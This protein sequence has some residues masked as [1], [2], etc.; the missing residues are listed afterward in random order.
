MYQL[1][2]GEIARMNS[3]EGNMAITTPVTLQVVS[4]IQPFGN[5]AAGGPTRYRCMVSDSELT[6]IAVLP[7]HLASLIEEAKISRYTVI[8]ITK[9]NVSKKARPGEAP[10]AFIIILEAE[11]LG[12]LEEKIG[13]P[14]KA[15]TGATS[16]PAQQ[17]QQQQQPVQPPQQ[18]NQPSFAQHQPSQQQQAYANTFMN[19]VEDTKPS[20]SA[21]A[22]APVHRGA[23]PPVHPIRDLNPYHNKWTIRARVTQK[24]PIKTWNKPSSQGRLFSVNLL[25]E[26]GEIRATTF[27]QQVDALYPLFEVGKVYYISNAQVKMARQQFSNVNNQYELTFDGNTSIEQCV[28]AVDM[29]QEHFDFIPLASLAKFEKGN[30]VDVLCVVQQADGVSEIT[31]K[32]TERKMVKRDLVLVDRSGFQVRATLWGQEAQAFDGHNEPVV[33]FKGIRVGDFGGRSLSLPS[34]G[35]I[36]VNPDI[37]EAHALRGW[38]D[39]EGRGAQFQ[40][41]GGEAGGGAPSQARFEAQLKTMAQVRDENLGLSDPVYFNLKGT[42]VFVRNTALAYP[43]CPSAECNKKVIED[44]S[45]RW[46]CE[47]CARSYDTPDYRYIFSVSVSDETG[48]NWLQCFD[49]VGRQLFGCT[50]R[51]MVELQAADEPAYQ[52]RLNEATFKEFQFRCRAKS[53]MFNET[54]RVRI[55]IVSM[56]PVDYAAESKRLARLIESYA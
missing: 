20:F 10:M 55:S 43:S 1:S 31:A 37:P 9:G 22:Q 32:S 12:T 3:A 7:S 11:V 30:V 6:A 18:Q 15:P 23:A 33:A 28:D 16:A 47:K 54:T 46:A 51:E 5:Q 4:N 41:F 34:L 25:D 14:Q 26:S 13:A 56:R 8:K 42:I 21:G 40:S 52:Q 44:N 27:T 36:T 29:P 45:G 39:N 53:D 48:Q 19:R 17:Q 24:S 35:T 38:Y 2:N 50:A 49:E